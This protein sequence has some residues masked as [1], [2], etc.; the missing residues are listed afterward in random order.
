MTELIEIDGKFYTPEIAGQIKEAQHNVEHYDLLQLTRKIQLNSLYGALLAKAFRWGVDEMI[1]ASVTYTGRAIT[2][3]MAN[4]AS[5]LI[6]GQEANLIKSFNL[7][8]KVVQNI[9]HSKNP[10]IIY[11]DTDSAYFATG[12]NDIE[13][14]VLIADAVAEGI[15]ESF[16]QFMRDAFGCQDGYD[17]LI[18]CGREIVAE[19]ALFQ[20]RKKYMAK[21][22]DLEGFRTNKMKAM[23]SEIKKSDTPKI[24]QKF[25]KNVVDR[26]LD[27][28]S[29]A[30]ISTYINQQRKELFT[31]GEISPSEVILLGISKSANNLELYTEAYFAELEGRPLKSKNGK[32]KMTVPGHI[33]ASVNYNVLIDEYNDNIHP[34]IMNGDK[35]KV[36]ELK[37]NEFGFKTLAFP[38]DLTKF[39]T[40]FLD[41]FE[42]DMKV[43]EE[44]LINAK[45]LGIFDAMGLEVPTPQTVRVNSIVQF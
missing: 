17:K 24:I 44:K 13:E 36:F 26:I 37:N 33:R 29:Y 39:P 4:T 1:G 12:A 28:M 15:N 14:A 40:W 38:A 27:G 32:G 42:I 34:K 16:P 25:L 7:D 6:S 11:S 19:R 23:G 18:V 22:V 8:K 10:V 21:V 43:S 41:N 45:L 9:Y 31:S 35:V 30:D 3:H 20:A 2:S 5:Y